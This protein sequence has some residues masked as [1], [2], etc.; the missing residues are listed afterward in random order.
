[1]TKK[2]KFSIKTKFENEVYC[3][4]PMLVNTPG[5][6]LS[7]VERVFYA[8]AIK[9]NSHWILEKETVRPNITAMQHTYWELNEYLYYDEFAM[10]RYHRACHLLKTLWEGHKDYKKSP[11]FI[12]EHFYDILGEEESDSLFPV[13]E[14]AHC[15]DLLQIMLDKLN[16]HYIQNHDDVWG[17]QYQPTEE[18]I[19]QLQACGAIETYLHQPSL[20]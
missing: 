9:D 20:F 11:E 17:H 10:P 8:V 14:C 2:N 15:A 1:M 13:M 6:E 16:W 5:I 4:F 3:G 19:E 12:E 18:L 7:I